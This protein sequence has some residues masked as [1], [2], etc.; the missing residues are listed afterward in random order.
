MFHKKSTPI[1]DGHNDSIPRFFYEH[2]ERKSFFDLHSTGHI[3][4]PRLQQANFIGGLFAIFV[5]SADENNKKRKKKTPAPAL[6]P[7]Y[8][9][10]HTCRMMTLIEKICEHEQVFRIEKAVDLQKC[11]TTNTLGIVVHFEGAEAIIDFDKLEFFYEKGLRSLG[12]V[13]SRPNQYAVGVPFTFPHT[14]DIGPGLTDKGK[15]LV[16]RCD[17]LGLVIDVSHLNQK[18]FWDVAKISQRPLVATHSNV[19]NICP[20]PRNLLDD[21]IKAIADSGGVIGINLGV[22][23]IRKDGKFNRDTKLQEIVAH[24]DYIVTK[25]GVDHVAFGSD[26]DGMYMATDIKDVTGMPK[27]IAALR[28]QGYS[29]ENLNKIAYGNW[30]RVLEEIL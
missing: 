11:Y 12:L 24:F 26:L 3:D 8:A 20:S 25:V 5:P 27:I 9:Y 22:P 28:M 14:P 29:E 15:E 13:W 1:F 19:H 16:K 7:V 10:E 30:F 4:F 23:F 6:D 18:G 21:Q 17:K 2:D